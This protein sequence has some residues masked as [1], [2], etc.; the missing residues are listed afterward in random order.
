MERSGPDRSRP[1]ALHLWRE[2]QESREENVLSG[3]VGQVVVNGWPGT[4]PKLSASDVVAEGTCG[5][6][7]TLKWRAPILDGL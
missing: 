6:I 1:S 5:R 2:A 4:V 7:A 3:I